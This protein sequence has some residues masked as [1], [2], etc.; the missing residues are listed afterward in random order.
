[1]KISIIIPTYKCKESLPELSDRLKKT[2]SKIELD[3]EM[4]FIDDRCPHNS[5]EVILE[6]AKNDKHIKG[7]RLSRNFGQHYAITA[8]LDLASGDYIVVMDCDLQDAPEEIERLYKKAQEGYDIVFG[9]RIDR[10]DSFLKKIT[11]KLFNMIL[12]YFTDLSHN[13]TIGNFGIYSKKVIDAIKLYKERARDFQLLAEIVGFKKC[14]IPIEHQKRKHG[15]SSYT[16]SKMLDLAIDSIVAHSNKPLRLSIKFG[17]GISFLALLYAIY[18]VVDYFCCN[19][20]VEG[21]TSLMVGM[22]FLF[23]IMFGLLG[24][25]GIYIGKIFDEV[26]NRPLYI[27]DEKINL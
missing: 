21:W 27:I 3:F 16:F 17:F 11:S 5:W 14:S 10:Q 9:E 6:L 25:L 8:G 2:L 4:I 26:K 22:V 19:E 13:H 18:L 20:P 7:I 1:M 23:G 15:T 24:V 12:D